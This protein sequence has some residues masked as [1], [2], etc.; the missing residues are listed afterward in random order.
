MFNEQ[1]LTDL[2][3]I[4]SY[5]QSVFNK[6]LVLVLTNQILPYLNMT[7]TFGKKLSKRTILI[8]DQLK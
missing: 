5:K 3:K 8:F 6:N 2:Q 7:Q 4:F 1:N